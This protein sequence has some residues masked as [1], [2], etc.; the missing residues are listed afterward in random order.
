MSLSG[1]NHSKQLAEHKQGKEESPGNMEWMEMS[2]RS[3]LLQKEWYINEG[4]DLKGGSESCYD[5][6]FGDGGEI[7]G[8]RN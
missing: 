8:V 4:E 3:D 7:E 5:V 1:V 6:R 2:D